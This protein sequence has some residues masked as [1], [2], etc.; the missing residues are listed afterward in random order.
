MQRLTGITHIVL[1]GNEI[2]HLGLVAQLLQSSFKELTC[3]VLERDEWYAVVEKKLLPAHRCLVIID[4]QSFSEEELIQKVNDLF[5]QQ[6]ELPVLLMNQAD[7]TD[8]LK[9][10]DVPNVKALF[11]M[12]QPQEQLI[13]AI[14]NLDNGQ[15]WLP[16]RY[17]HHIA[18]KFRKAPV[19]KLTP[20]VELTQREKQVLALM[21]RG[22]PIEAMATE[23][24]LS[25]NT[26]KTHLYRTYK[27]INVHN[28]QQAMQWLQ[29]YECDLEV[30]HA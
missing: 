28:R 8:L 21:S 29:R 20:P 12:H 18:M 6:P 2:F 15:L 9:L 5:M 7:A 27:K 24:F 13:A 1:F 16:R 4:T 22:L 26:V 23:L 17:L 30:Q 25:P 11:E 3:E 19:Q 14:Q 10:M